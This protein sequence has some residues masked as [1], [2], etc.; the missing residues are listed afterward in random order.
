MSAWNPASLDH[1]QAAEVF[2]RVFGKP[3]EFHELPIPAGKEFYQ[4]F[5]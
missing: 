3:V 4:M 1:Q 5:R 2:S